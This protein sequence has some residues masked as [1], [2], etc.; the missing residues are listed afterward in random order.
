MMG[1]AT[2]KLEWLGLQ[3]QKVRACIAEVDNTF[4]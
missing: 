4:Q 2:D 1:T 3:E